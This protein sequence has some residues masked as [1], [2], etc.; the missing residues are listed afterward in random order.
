MTEPESPNSQP[1]PVSPATIRVDLLMDGPP[2]IRMRAL[3]ETLNEVM[4]PSDLNFAEA[5]SRSG[6]VLSAGRLHVLVDGSDSP[7]SSDHLAPALG[8]DLGKILNENWADFAKRHCASVSLTV[9]AGPDPHAENA[10]GAVPDREQIEIMM[11]VAHVAAT[12]LATDCQ[13][14]AVHWAP[15]HQLFA[16]KRFLAMGDMLFPLPL[17]LHPKP[18]YSS[19]MDGAHQSVGFDLLGAESLIG[20]ALRFREA[21]ARFDW[22]VER[23]LA[24]VAHCRAM[25]QP[26][27]AGDSFGTAEGERIAL[28]AIPDG[29]FALVLKERDGIMMLQPEP[30]EAA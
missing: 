14:I 28:E 15:C 23:A 12:F 8:S 2:S 4:G 5:E 10:L 24:F 29:G 27:A 30:R 11:T 21:P 9:G 1:A 7:L 22:L 16:P 6:L 17:F 20:C 18:I 19:R 3:A 26:L 13:P 25:G